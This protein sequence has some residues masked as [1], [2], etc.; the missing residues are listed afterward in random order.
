[1]AIRSC[2]RVAHSSR[3]GLGSNGRRWRHRS[4]QLR[5]DDI[6]PSDRPQHGGHG[7]GDALPET[8]STEGIACNN[9]HHNA[10]GANADTSSFFSKEHTEDECNLPFLPLE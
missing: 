8:S 6:D 2:M 9:A 1:M 3:E 5:R 7:G 10:T 4:P